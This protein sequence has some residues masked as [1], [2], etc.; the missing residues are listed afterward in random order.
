MTP[1]EKIKELAYLAK[2]EHLH[3]DEDIYYSCHADPERMEIYPE[4]DRSCTCNAERINEQINE[5]LN[6]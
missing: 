2:R 3:I 5:I 6:A 1:H 4:D